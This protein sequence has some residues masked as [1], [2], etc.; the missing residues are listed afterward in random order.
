MDCMVCGAVVVDRDDGYCS[1]SCR[2][3]HLVRRRDA[4]L[5]KRDSISSKRTRV[6]PRKPAWRAAVHHNDGRTVSYCNHRHRTR[7]SAIECATR[8]Y[9]YMNDLAKAER[10]PAD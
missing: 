9:D 10:W 5:A 3:G 7:G 1:D 6:V 8:T 4:V 2:Y